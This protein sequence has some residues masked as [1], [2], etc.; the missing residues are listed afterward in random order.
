MPKKAYIAIIVLAILVVASVA[1]IYIL[2]QPQGNQTPSLAIGVKAG[3]TF[4]YN[5]TGTTEAYNENTTIP[6]NFLAVNMTEYYKVTITDVE[7]PIVSYNI[8]WQFKNGTQY[9]YNGKLNVANGAN[10]QDFNYIYP[11][12]LALSSP[13]RPELTDGPTVNETQTS[14][15]LNGDRQTNIIRQ[16]A[17]YYDSTDLTY[18]KMYY[19]YKYIYVDSQTGMLVQFRDRQVYTDPQIILT[20]D[21]NLIDSNVLQVS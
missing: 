9:N 1:A 6:E 17:V 14:T 11:A 20:V 12:N 3:D 2:Q 7:S 5:M 21:W 13:V 10:T 15:Y 4:T 8:I 19:D 16:Q 18:T